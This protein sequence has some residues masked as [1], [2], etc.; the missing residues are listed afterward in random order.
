MDNNPVHA[1]EREKLR[2]WVVGK[3]SG[4]VKIN[5]VIFAVSERTGWTWETSRQFVQEIQE[6]YKKEIQVRRFPVFAMGG[7]AILLVGIVLLATSIETIAPILAS[8]ISGVDFN[9]AVSVFFE[10]RSGYF[11]LIKIFTGVAMIIAG[12]IGMWQAITFLW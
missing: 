12:F 9:Q 11:E 1:L 10:A 8:L 7:T 3:V 6:D 2:L 4:Y 5:N